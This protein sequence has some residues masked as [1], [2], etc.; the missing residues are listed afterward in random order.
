MLSEK[1]PLYIKSTYCKIPLTWHKSKLKQSVLRKAT[2]LITLTWGL[3]YWLGNSLKEIAGAQNCSRSW[4]G[5]QTH[6]AVHWG[7]VYSACFKVCM[8]SLNKTKIISSILVGLA[9]ILHSALLLQI[10][11]Q[12]HYKYK[13][14]IFIT[15]V[16][17]RRLDD[18]LEKAMRI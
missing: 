2:L 14:F 4:S 15:Y 9:S 16:E 17:V 3:G 6:L 10:K 5:I 11:I 12:R 7:L 18:H 1:K 8:L 13:G